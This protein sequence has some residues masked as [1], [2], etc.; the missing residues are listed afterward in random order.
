M[1]HKELVPL[2][3]KWLAKKHPIVITEMT[4][5]AL[6]EPDAIGFHGGFS[7]LVE[8]KASRADFFADFKKSVARR[9]ERMGDKKLY[10]VPA[11]ILEAHEIPEKWGLLEV[12]A[13]KVVE[14][15][16]AMHFDE[17]DYRG[18]AGLLVSAIRRIGQ[19]APVGCSVKC[20]T[21]ETKNRAT[22]GVAVDEIE[23][24]KTPVSS[25]GKAVC[26]KCGQ[27]WCICSN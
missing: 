14:V 16:P 18:E 9:G 21:Y 15:I 5:G 6:E 25:P 12:R 3:A 17:K 11:G 8:C 26:E 24:A 19:A 13:G 22:L 4:S 10:L 23:P 27:C 7:T 2:A 20:Y 1:T